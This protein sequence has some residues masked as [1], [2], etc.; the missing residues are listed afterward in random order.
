LPT[1]WGPYLYTANVHPAEVALSMIIGG[2]GKV[3]VVV[4]GDWAAPSCQQ[5]QAGF[6][7]YKDWC[8][9]S[10]GCE[11]TGNPQQGEFTVF[12]QYSN[13]ID[14]DDMKRDQ[15]SKLSAFNGKMKN[16]QNVKC[17]LFLLSWTL[18]P[19]SDVASY[20]VPA[21]RN[22]ADA[23]V[24]V[25]PNGY[26]FIPNVIY[27][28]YYERARVTDTAIG[29]MTSGA[30]GTERACGPRPGDPVRWPARLF[31]KLSPSRCTKV[32]TVR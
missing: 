22:L 13:T 8:S 10:N 11:S 12:D 6:Y 25:R 5:Q 7:V 1:L 26:G 32:Q 14:Y 19:I 23:M 24:N 18:T 16:A 29:M 21:N 30:V 17:D 9:G 15:L 27:V 31:L 3:V 2:A 4:D 28:D 20:S